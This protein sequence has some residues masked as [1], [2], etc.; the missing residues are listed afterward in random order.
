MN[1]DIRRIL[2]SALLALSAALSACG[3]GGSAAPETPSPAATGG[4]VVNS[5]LKATQ[6]GTTYAIQTFLPASYATGTTLL[7][8]IYVTEGDAPYGVATGSSV[9]GAQSRFDTFRQAM[10]R[11][12]TQA[13]LVGINGTARRNTDFLLPGAAEYVNF[14]AKDLAPSIERQYRADPARRALS[15]LSHGGYLVVAALV[16]E[17][18]AGALSFSHYLSTESSIGGHTGL[19]AYLEFEKQLDASA[20][21]VPATLFLAGASTANGPL[22]VT[23]LH[24]QMATHNHAGLTLLKAEY[25][26]THVGSDL[27]AFE[28]AL[29]RFF[30]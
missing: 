3:G 5:G 13:I 19:P 15:G 28:E 26:A 12:G 11:R 14:I 24:A 17:G 27:P 16:L 20:R 6:N 9:G 4:Q 7:P 18:S 29:A 30:P 10:Q 8:T 23:P 25:N 1:R 21:P 2:F 22:V